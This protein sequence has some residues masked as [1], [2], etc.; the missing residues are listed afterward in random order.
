MNSYRALPEIG[1]KFHN[2]LIV[3][4]TYGPRQEFT[5]ICHELIWEGQNGR[6]DEGRTSIRFGGVTNLDGVKDF[7]AT[8]PY[9]RSE[10]DLIDYAKN[11]PSKV[12]HIFVELSFERTQAKLTVECRN[13]NISHE[14]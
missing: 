3:D 1:K 8:R 14:G 13:I 2:A 12:D 11:H 5:L 9:Q 4:V 10:V 6:Y 7:F